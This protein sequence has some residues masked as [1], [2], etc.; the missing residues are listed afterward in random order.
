L[1]AVNPKFIKQTALIETENL[2]YIENGKI[3]KYTKAY[4]IE[5]KAGITL[6]TKIPSR[7]LDLIIRNCQW[8][9]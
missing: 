1:A 2:R 9:E 5:K 7:L 8:V 3:Q 4:Q 6:G